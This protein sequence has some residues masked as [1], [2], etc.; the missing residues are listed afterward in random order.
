MVFT[1]GESHPRYRHGMSQSLLYK[2]W[3]SMRARCENPNN[4]HYKNYGARGI[5][6]C[7]RWASFEY[8]FEDMGEPPSSSH[9]LE[10]IDNNGPYSPDNCRWATDSEQSRNTRRTR[11]VQFGADVLC[12]K[13]LAIRV[14]LPYKRVQERLRNGFALDEATSSCVL[15]R[16]DARTIMLDGKEVPLREA[17]NRFG[18]KIST[19]AAR[20]ERGWD[21]LRAVTTPTSQGKEA[22]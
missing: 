11:L 2:K 17:S 7:E 21:P 1:K 5:Y 8:F 20:L 22:N 15:Q 19:I 14:G 10:R 16:R 3:Q 4:S 13:D 18:I 6:V 12:A 9:S